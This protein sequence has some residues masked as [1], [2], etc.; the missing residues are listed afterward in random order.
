MYQ[1]I[2]NAKFSHFNKLQVSLAC[3]GRERSDGEVAKTGGEKERQVESSKTC[4]PPLTGF[5]RSVASLVPKSEVFECVAHTDANVV[6][7][8]PTGSGKTCVF[9]MAIIR[10]LQRQRLEEPSLGTTKNFSKMNKIVYIAPSKALCDERLNDWQG[11]FIRLGLTIGRV[12]GDSKPGEAM[13]TVAMSHVILTTPEKWDSLTRKWKDHIYLLGNISL[14]MIDEVHILGDK[15]RG[16]TL[17]SVI[18]RMK[19]VRRTAQERARAR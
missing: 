12:T 16:A 2:F 13:R 17:E 18:T 19:T 7:A 9:E 1:T 15:N 5:A 14:L 4:N 3:L 6:V 8:A 10:L 11:R